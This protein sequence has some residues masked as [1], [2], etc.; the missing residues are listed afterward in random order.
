[1]ARKSNIV[2]VS[3]ADFDQDKQLLR[4][5]VKTFHNLIVVEI[6]WSKTNQFDSRLLRPPL[7]AIPSSAL[8]PVSAY[9]HMTGLLPAP[10][11]DPAFCVMK[12]LPLVYSQKTVAA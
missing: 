7:I 3:Y 5:D 6:K 1:M 11:G 4:R 12:A 2:P 10:S 9:S 8:C